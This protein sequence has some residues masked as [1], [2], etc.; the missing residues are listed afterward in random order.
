MKTVDITTT[1]NVTIQYDIATLFDRVVAFILDA[2]IKWA[3]IGIIQFILFQ[4]GIRWEYAFALLVAFVEYFYNPLFEIYLNGQT[5]GKRILRI[6]VI[7]MDGTPPKSIDFFTRWTFQL[8]ETYMTLGTLSSLM[9]WFSS[10]GQRIGDIVANTTVIKQN[11]DNRFK[12]NKLMKLDTLK[13]HQP[14]YPEV[15][16]FNEKEM[17]I[18]KE[19]L[20]RFQKYPNQGHKDAIRELSLKAQDFLQVT[21]ESKSHIKFL[22]TLLKDYVSLTR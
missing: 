1:Q 12:L 13:E 4:I 21:P 7:K 9:V 22:N 20:V 3:G 6:K 11:L 18:I 5:P 2:M 17:L 10:N 16:Q 8:F 15:V 19:S 14:I